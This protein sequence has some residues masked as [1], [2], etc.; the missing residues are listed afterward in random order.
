M[1]RR[2]FMATFVVL[3]LIV[4]PFFTLF[5]YLGLDYRLAA[6]FAFVAGVLAASICEVVNS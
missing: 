5:V 3:V 2:I 6:L 4:A 1:Y